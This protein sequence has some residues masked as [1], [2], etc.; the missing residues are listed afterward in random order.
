M[1]RNL[2]VEGY[3]PLDKPRKCACGAEYLTRITYQEGRKVKLR[4]CP[5]CVFKPD[6]ETS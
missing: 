5:R 4:E 6:K 2:P 3:C 1:S